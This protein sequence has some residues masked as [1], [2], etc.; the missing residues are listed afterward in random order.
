MIQAILK[1]LEL[2]RRDFY[3]ETFPTKYKFYL[4]SE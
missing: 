1:Y 4:D 2:H 3:F